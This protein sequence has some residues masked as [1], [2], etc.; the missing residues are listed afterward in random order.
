[1]WDTRYT[2][3]DSV[4]HG[5]RKFAA[6]ALTP[7]RC[8]DGFGSDH[9]VILRAGRT[10]AFK[11]RITAEDHGGLNRMYKVRL[12]LDRPW[13]PMLVVSS[14]VALLGGY[15]ARFRL[16]H[17][18]W[19]VPEAIVAAL[20]LIGVLFKVSRHGGQVLYA[21]QQAS[22]E[23]GIQGVGEPA[24]AADNHRPAIS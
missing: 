5:L 15:L 7:V 12:R 18:Q 13:L 14:S 4:L 24:P 19:L 20:I 9:D 21:L 2:P 11:L 10:Y 16:I 6:G 8:D 23:Y 22:A 17:A 3:I 1:M